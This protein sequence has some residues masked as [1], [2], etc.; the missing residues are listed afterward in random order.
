MRR[1][2]Y[3][4]ERFTDYYRIDPG[5]IIDTWATIAESAEIEAQNALMEK[6]QREAGH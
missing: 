1:C 6:A 5:P 3:L 2:R 4:G